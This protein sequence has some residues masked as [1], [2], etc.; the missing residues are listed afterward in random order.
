MFSVVPIWICLCC[1][2]EGFHQ[3]CLELLALALRLPK[4]FFKHLINIRETS[5]RPC[6]TQK[7]NYLS[8][9]H[10][11]EQREGGIEILLR[12]SW[13]VNQ[14]RFPGIKATTS[15]PCSM[16][17]SPASMLE[18][19]SRL[20]DNPKEGHLCSAEQLQEELRPPGAGRLDLSFLC[21]WKLALTHTGS[22]CVVKFDNRRYFMES[23]AFP[24]Q[25]QQGIQE[26]LQKYW[27]LPRYLTQVC[28]SLK[29]LNKSH[30]PVPC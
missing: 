25:T 16:A 12:W 18:G 24:P 23:L 20:E 29:S 26:L 21:S 22:L 14:V 13:G 6:E 1:S 4:I 11:W 7:R 2:K 19:Q 15:I 27:Q 8:T 10:G 9:F 30:I 17:L 5:Q 3:D 28:N